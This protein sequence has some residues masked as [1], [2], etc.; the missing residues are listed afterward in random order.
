MNAYEKLKLDVYESGLDS[1]IC[2]G[3]LEIMETCSDDDAEEVFSAVVEIV[4][5]AKTD[6]TKPKKQIDISKGIAKTALVGGAGLTINGGIT[7]GI[8]AATSGIYDI[9][10]EKLKK[11]FNELM[12]KVS[13]EENPEKRRK[14]MDK[15]IILNGD[16]R[17]CKQKIKDARKKW[18]PVLPE[19]GLDW[20]PAMLLV[21][22]YP[23]LILTRKRDPFIRN[24]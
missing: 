23:I 4:N 17:E 5:E 24:P 16:I 20:Q 8:G 13:K 12:L 1:D 6:S 15:M 3:I 10:L 7:A 21:D 9:K 11:K 19:L 14:I 18:G 2:N 22:A